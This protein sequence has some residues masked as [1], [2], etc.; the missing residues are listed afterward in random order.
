MGRSAKILAT[1][2]DAAA[3]L[4]AG[5]YADSSTKI[6]LV[7]GTGVNAAVELPVSVLGPDKFGSRPPSWKDD[8]PQNVLVNTELS[9]YGNTVLPRTSWD[10][11]LSN[12]NALPGFQPLE[13]L[14]GGRYLGEIVRL[15]V[16]DAVNRVGLLGGHMPKRLQQPFSLE[17]ATLAGIERY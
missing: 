9:V 4:M 8:A 17:T 11:I 14:I 2:N 12:L 13:Y 10:D 15:I 1:V 16:V 5:A 7:L 3:T 6:G